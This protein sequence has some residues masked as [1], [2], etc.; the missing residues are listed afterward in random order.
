[1]KAATVTQLKKELQHLSEAEL[2]ETCLRLAKFKKENKELLSYLLFEADNEERYILSIKEEM[3]EEFD[4]IN[5][6][7]YY[8]IKKSIR[9]ILRNLKKYIRYSKKDET[10]VELLIYFCQKLGD[11]SPSIKHNTVLTNTYHRQLAL[12]KNGLLK[13]HEDIQY[14]YKIE[15][16]NLKL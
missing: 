9:K 15:I 13:M 5:T 10:Q 12:A 11:L 6:S 7:S 2:I 3:D 4:S 14:D 16:E 1:M 8:F